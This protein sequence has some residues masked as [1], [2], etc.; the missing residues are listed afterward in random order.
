MEY[1]FIINLFEDQNIGTCSQT[2]SIL[3]RN[4]EPK[5]NNSVYSITV[6]RPIYFNPY[7]LQYG[8]SRNHILYRN[9]FFPPVIVRKDCDESMRP[10]VIDW[11]ILVVAVWV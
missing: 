7:L 11:L 1:I 9:L 3:E 6:H 2:Y 8:S 4:N 10:S 5:K